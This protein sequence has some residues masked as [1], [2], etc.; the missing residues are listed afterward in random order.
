MMEPY[1]C[2]DECAFPAPVFRHEKV[3]SRDVYA[4]GHHALARE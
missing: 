3:A 1:D 4:T 2:F